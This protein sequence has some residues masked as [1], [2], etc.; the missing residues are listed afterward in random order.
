MHLL[1]ALLLSR[2]PLDLRLN[3]GMQT[4]LIGYPIGLTY[5]HPQRYWAV[6][7]LMVSGKGNDPL[8]VAYQAI[9]LPLS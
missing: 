9:A 7:L 6:C 4:L 5:F 1:C 3:S 2:I 8:S